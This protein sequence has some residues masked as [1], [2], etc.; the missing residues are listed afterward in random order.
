M[1]SHSRWSMNWGLQKAPFISLTCLQNTDAF[2]THIVCVRFI[3]LPAPQHDLPPRHFLIVIW[4]WS[5]MVHFLFNPTLASPFRT[6][7]YFLDIPDRWNNLTMHRTHRAHHLN[8]VQLGSFIRDFLL[9]PCDVTDTFNSGCSIFPA[10]ALIFISFAPCCWALVHSWGGYKYK[11]QWKHMITERQFTHL[12]RWLLL[13]AWTALC[14]KPP[15]YLA[16]AMTNQYW[17]R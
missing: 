11:C 17:R 1:F 7:F 4:V 14:A 13:L 6:S 15:N 10:Q 2:F 16:L 8:L 5:P 12:G 3:F 9:V